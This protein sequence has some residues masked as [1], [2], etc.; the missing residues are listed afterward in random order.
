MNCLS[1][2]DGV[3]IDV[4]FVIDTSN[5]ISDEQFETMID[6]MAKLVLSFDVSES[7]IH[8]A[9]IT[10]ANRPKAQI[11]LLDYQERIPLAKAVYAL[12]R[13]YGGSYTFCAIDLVLEHGLLEEYGARPGVPKVGVVVVDG[14]SADPERTE[15]RAAEARQAG[16]R[17]IAVGIGDAVDMD[18]LKQ[19]A[20]D[21]RLVYTVGGFDTLHEHIEPVA[22]STC[23]GE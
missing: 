12:H 17:M 11:E 8:V 5:S 7:N 13:Q 23:K 21:D 15:L 20:G 22:K 14:K 1:E 19:I 16:I 9:V 4:I 18:E 10:F 6:F 3:A 2:C